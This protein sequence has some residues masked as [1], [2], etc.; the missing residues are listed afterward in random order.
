[1][2]L[3]N[4]LFFP[5]LTWC[6]VSSGIVVVALSRPTGDFITDFFGLRTLEKLQWSLSLLNRLVDDAITA[7]NA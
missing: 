2:N 7:D 6:G 3:V 4:I 5:R 1:M